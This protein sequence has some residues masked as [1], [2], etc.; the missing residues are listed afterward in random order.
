MTTDPDPTEL[1]LLSVRDVARL[2]QVHPRSI[3]RLAA[4][5]VLPAPVRL[6]PKLVRW[7]A[8]DISRAIERAAQ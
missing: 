5:G 1:Q 8:A 6:G 3:W 2:L 7:R 4:A